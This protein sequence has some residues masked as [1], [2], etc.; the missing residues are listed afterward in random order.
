MK[1]YNG[2]CLELMK[3][4]PDGSVDM[5]LDDLPYGTTDCAFDKRLPFEPMWAEFK[6]VT[7]HN[8]A[9]VLFSQMPFGAELIMS[10]RK[11]FR[12]E[13]CWEKSLGV[14]F[15]NAKKM[16]LRCHENILV[17][18][19]AL[20]TYNPQFAQGKPYVN[21]VKKSTLNYGKCNRQVTISDGRRYPRD[22]VKFY[23]VGNFNHTDN[24]HP[25]QKPVGLLEYLIKTYTNAGETVLDA[26]MGSGS[27]GVACVDTG[28][29][30]VGI[31]LDETFY[32]IAQERIAK[33]Q[34]LKAQELF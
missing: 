2:D 8:A 26:T 31:E 10:N 17:F 23:Q 25:Q 30:F 14:G 32:K 27:T 24:Y 19:Q 16:P 4:I 6:R 5:I 33:A 28:R 11:M 22:I 13:W 9:I 15:L 1:L 34:A 29:K 21:E 20:P 3:E 7:K 18:Y 12:Y